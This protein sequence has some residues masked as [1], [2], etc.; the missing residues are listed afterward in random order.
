MNLSSTAFAD[1]GSI[2]AHYTCD[3]DRLMNPPLAFSGVP[4]RAA[5]LALIMEDPD[6]PKALR[7]EP[8]DHWV[9]FNIPPGTTGI[10]EGGTAGIAGVNS[11]NEMD[12]TGPCPPPQ[13]KPA[14][15][16]Y[17]FTLY[18]LDKMLDLAAG[19]SKA[20]LLAAMQ[21]RIVAR[22]Q[23]VGRYRRMGV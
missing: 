18:A 23:L 22:A 15:H 21:G 9:L 4:P 8:F 5:S 7:S 11:R 3:G 19:S 2:P 1:G 17:I 16:R 10:P 12:Y 13:Y 20:E 14:T 6:V